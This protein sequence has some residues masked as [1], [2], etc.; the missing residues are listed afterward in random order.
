MSYDQTQLVIG[1]L[2]IDYISAFSRLL[3]G[4]FLPRLLKKAQ[5]QGGKRGEARGLLNT[6][7]AAPRK[8]A[9]AADGF[10]SAAC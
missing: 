7:A 1:L 2:A 6:H 5:A 9:N 3:K 10:F 8:R 4:P